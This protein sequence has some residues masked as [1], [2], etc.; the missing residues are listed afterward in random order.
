[1]IS[2]VAAA[3]FASSLY[4][5]PINTGLQFNSVNTSNSAEDEAQGD[6][7]IDFKL[8]QKDNI[9]YRF[10]RAYQNNPSANSQGMAT[11]RRRFTTRLATGLARSETIG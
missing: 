4:P 10:T 5:T 8:T 9:S 2:P 6:L 11:E 3:L 7:R 1:M